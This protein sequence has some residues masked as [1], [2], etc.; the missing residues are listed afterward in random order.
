MIIRFVTLQDAQQFYCYVSFS[1]KKVLIVNDGFPPRGWG[2]ANTIAYLHAKGLLERGFEVQVFTTTQDKNMPIGASMYEGISVHTFYTD[3]LPRWWAYKSLNNRELTK[4]FEK[5]LKAFSPDIV[6]FHNIHHYFSYRSITIAKR[7]GAKVFLTAHDV[8]SFAYQKLHNFIDYS[9]TAIPTAFNY[10]VPWLVNLKDARLRYNPLRNFIIRRCLKQVD[11][12]FAVSEALKQALADNGIKGNVSVV[13]NGIDS[14]R[15]K[16]CPPHNEPTVLFVG[17]F[18]PDK[19]R[20]VTLRAFAKV[21]E[22]IPEAQLHVIG[23]PVGQK[24][25][26]MDALIDELDI[27]KNIVL[28]PPVPYPQMPE[29]YCKASVVAVPS[30]IFD[31]FPTANLEAMAAGKPVIATCFGGSCEVV[32]NGVTGFIINPLDIDLLAQKITTLLQDEALAARFGAAGRTR[33]TKEFSLE[34][35]LAQYGKFY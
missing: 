8:M 12:I 10:H 18:T 17:R 15:F 9:S 7:S 26:V 28:H 22:E 34:R 33:L 21:V 5:E 35:Q 20:D 19:G 16:N 32:E 4:A 24:E 13:H 30:I 25:P 23:F 3:Y 2:G 1:M 11:Q 14:E 27:R 31:S 29:Q 6:H